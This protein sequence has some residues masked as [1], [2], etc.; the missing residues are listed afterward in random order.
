MIESGTGDGKLTRMLTR[1]KFKQGLD[2]LKGEF[3]HVIS[4]DYDHD[5][6]RIEKANSH[7]VDV[8]TSLESN[9]LSMHL[10]DK[11][12]DIEKLF[13]DDLDDVGVL[14][15]ADISDPD[16][17]TLV[18]SELDVLSRFADRIRCIIIFQVST[19]ETI[20]ITEEEKT[21]VY[22]EVTLP[23]IQNVATSMF[24]AASSEVVFNHM[25]IRR[26]DEPSGEDDADDTAAQDEPS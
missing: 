26:L 6:K 17:F 19:L 22:D 18:L 11:P 16:R 20:S 14:L 5:E 15:R 3:E 1:V 2:H 4:F 7:L 23:H 8:T 12:Q 10:C 25:V 13:S 24:P 9:R 21:G